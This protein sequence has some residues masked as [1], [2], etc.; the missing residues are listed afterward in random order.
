MEAG[1][2]GSRYGGRRRIEVDFFGNARFGELSSAM[3][4]EPVDFDNIRAHGDGERTR[5]AFIWADPAG[6]RSRYKA[7][8]KDNRNK[9]KCKAGEETGEARLDESWQ[10]A[11]SRAT[12]RRSWAPGRRGRRERS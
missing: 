10:R 5:T 8:D 4:G 9:Y 11:T 3:S 1:G 2:D 6:V 12:R 7:S